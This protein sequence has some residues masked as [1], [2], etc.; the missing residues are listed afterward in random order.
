MTKFVFVTGGVVSSLG[1]GIAAASLAALLESRGLK[2][3]LIKLDPYI[4][5]DPG[6]MSPFQHGEVFVTDDGAETDLD[7]G[8]YERYISTRM[9]KVNNFTTGQI[10]ESVLRKERRG[11]YL[12]KTVQV[13]PHI[14]N[15]IQEF[16]RYGSGDAVKDGFAPA[17]HVDVAI[18]EIGGTVGDI[19]SLP[20]L[21]AVRQLSLRMGRNDTAFV[22]L[23]LVPYIPSAGELKTKPTQH[24]VQKMR[25]IG[26]QPDALL[27]RADRKIP[28]DERAKISMFSNVRESAV[29]SVWD[30]DTIYRV[31]RM[32]HEQGL[33]DIICDKLDIKAPP[34]NLSK[35]DALVHTL[36]EPK[37]AV[38][39]AMVGKYTD[40][41]DSY[42]SLNEALKHAGVQHDAKVDITYVDSETLEPGN[43]AQLAKFDAVLVP[44]GFGARGIEGK[45]LA[46]KFARESKTPYLGICLGMQ[47]A[48]IEYAR[49]VAG[50][51][52]ANSTEFDA[53][54]KHPVIALI[55][56][57]KD[58]D[59]TIKT[60]DA[61]SDLGGTMRL[62]AQ[63]SDV[64]AGT[65]AHGIYGDVVDERHRH[66]YE[67][68]V[69][70]LDQLQKAGLVISA[71][72]QREKLT[73]IVEL[74]QSVHPWFVGVQFHPEF[75]SRPFTGHPL[76]NAYVK[77]ALAHKASGHVKAAA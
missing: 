22:H 8:H 35:W 41:S 42:K 32:L 50:L 29:V 76:F 6:T 37:N 48:T 4:N 64:K 43:I 19:E 28:E 44:G 26:I 30:A 58:K 38:N 63:S 23:T 56:E 27:C 24:S 14:T 77:S 59:G 57:W 45:I 54:C 31:P 61:N 69:N 21:E 40:L 74:P 39:I 36:T 11:D 53:Q 73:E 9:R 20:F 17:P 46:A 7:L 33:D 71:L 49:N 2:V 66:R 55:T 12:G 51:T 18:V 15:E 3:T 72:T 60:R 68:N 1:K 16:I 47:V 34:A 65:V 25:E 5:V 70:Y 52:D 13:I 75:K 67:A 10:Y 62:G